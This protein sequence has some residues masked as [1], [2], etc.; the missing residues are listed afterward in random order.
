MAISK[1]DYDAAFI[2]QY[3]WDKVGVKSSSKSSAFSKKPF[4]T[5]VS[6]VIKGGLEQAV[7][8][9]YT[10]IGSMSFFMDISTMLSLPKQ[11]F[12]EGVPN[13][14]HMSCPLKV[15]IMV[16]QELAKRRDGSGETDMVFSVADSESD[17]TAEGDVSEDE[18]CPLGALPTRSQTSLKAKA[19]HLPPLDVTSPLP[20]DLPQAPP[21]PPPESAHLTAQEVFARIPPGVPVSYVTFPPSPAAAAAAAAAE[22]AVEACAC[23]PPEALPPLAKKTRNHAKS[24]GPRKPPLPPVPRRLRAKKKT[25]AKHSEAQLASV[26]A[27]IDAVARGADPTPTVDLVQQALDVSGAKEELACLL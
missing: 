3:L 20:G 27:T 11:S 18:G 7:V 23:E 8:G 1:E 17:W 25:A 12:G 13:K 21:T 26:Q 10:C 22:P 15:P 19:S 14:V 9:V 4:S 5:V 6:T 2:G 16:Q 24:R